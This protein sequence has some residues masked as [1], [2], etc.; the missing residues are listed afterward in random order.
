V[1]LPYKTDGDGAGW[2]E[3]YSYPLYGEYGVVRGVIHYLRDI[4]ERRMLEE[5]AR[6]NDHLAA[7]GQISA[8]I[9]HEINNPNHIIMANTELL[10]DVWQD[11]DSVL[12]EYYAQQGDFL[13]GGLPFSEMR[14]KVDTMIGR[15]LKGSVRIN[16]IVLGMKQYTSQ[17][18]HVPAETVVINDVVRTCMDMLNDQIGK[19]TDAF[20][21][22]LGADIPLVKGNRQALEEVITNLV[23]NA[24]QAL[25]NRAKGV[26]VFTR[27][28]RNDNSVII[29]V[30]DEGRGMTSD[31]LRLATSPFYT[32][33]QNS[34]GMGLGLSISLAIVKN[35]KGSL[36]FESEPGQGTVA[37]VRLPVSRD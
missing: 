33:K 29:E 10:K 36:D 5:R 18:H 28:D 32:T 2:L 11:A 4:T 35:H 1:T 21:V 15:I 37:T 3:K 13:L 12:S 27:H 20:T 26:A 16:S 9:A 17:M 24:L 7:L 22:D 19:T 30:R 23:S 8:G 34:G 6:R 31:V 14:I 25:A